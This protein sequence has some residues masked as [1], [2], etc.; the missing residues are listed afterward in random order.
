[1]GIAVPF[2][3]TSPSGY[4]WFDDE[5]SFAPDVHLALEAPTTTVMLADLG[6]PS[7]E[8]R[9]KAT[10]VAATAP[11]RVLSDEG[12]EVMLDVARR[13]RAFATPAADRIERM[14]RGGCYRSKWLRD[15]CIAPELTDHMSAIYQTEVAPHA[16]PL[17]LGHLNFEPT[18]AGKA[19]DKWHHD[20]LPLDF[21]L[22]VTDP[23]GIDGGSFEY[24][25]GTKAEAATLAEQGKVPPVER[26]EVPEFPG[27]GYAI[28]L[29]GDMVVHRAAPLNQLTERI[30]MVNGYVAMD[31]L[32]DEQ[33]RCRDLMT[34]D[35]HAVLWTEWAR[36]AAWR[37]EGRL[38]DLV[39]TLEFTDDRDEVIDALEAAVA[40]AQQAIE[41]MRAGPAPA[42]HYER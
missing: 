3:S 29:H 24:F 13:L 11:F 33:S 42:L 35:D 14:T 41:Q 5:P 26:T 34:V 15:F 23:N 32:L 40:D 9:T 25:R 27:A 17:H 1:M 39:A 21:V 16:M 10:P 18:E 28:A 7:D 30:S 22:M 38:A 20:T 2:P 8:I 4:E 12:V 31:R 37:S 36:F 19:I 6:Y